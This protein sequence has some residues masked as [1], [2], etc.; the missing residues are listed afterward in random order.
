MT[1]VVGGIFFNVQPGTKDT[2]NTKADKNLIDVGK[3]VKLEPTKNTLI[4]LKVYLQVVSFLAGALCN[5]QM[6][7]CPA[8]YPFDI[9]QLKVKS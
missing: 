6:I 1:L 8:D 4:F 7:L 3:Q 2:Q 9:C 5:L